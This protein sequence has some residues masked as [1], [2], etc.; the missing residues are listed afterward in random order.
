MA[1][2]AAVPLV[3]VAVLVLTGVLGYILDRTG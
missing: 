2:S 1:P 3:V